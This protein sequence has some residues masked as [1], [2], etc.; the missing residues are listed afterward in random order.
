MNYSIT[1]LHQESKTVMVLATTKT[2]NGQPG[3]PLLDGPFRV[4]G[5]ELWTVQTSTQF[6]DHPMEPVWHLLTISV[7]LI[8]TV[9]LRP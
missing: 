3:L 6:Q 8:C 7:S 4:F 2:V 1:T 5:T 9:T